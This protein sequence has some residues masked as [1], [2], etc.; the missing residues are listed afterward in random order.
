[1]VTWLYRWRE[2]GIVHFT[3]D[4]YAADAALHNGY[5]VAAE[6]IKDERTLDA[7]R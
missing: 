4:I 2:K 3:T 6:M 1:M 5:P 7:H